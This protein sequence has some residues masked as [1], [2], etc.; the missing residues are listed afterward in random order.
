MALETVLYASANFRDYR[1]KMRLVNDE[2]EFLKGELRWRRVEESLEPGN[3]NLL[4]LKGQLLT[5]WVSRR[6]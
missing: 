6:T 3:S 2:S 5:R 1:A 4:Y